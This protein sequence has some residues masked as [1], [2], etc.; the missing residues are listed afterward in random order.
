ML[1]LQAEEAGGETSDLPVTLGS[2]RS[3]SFLYFNGIAWAKK[4]SQ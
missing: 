4:A 2:K 1:S 3:V